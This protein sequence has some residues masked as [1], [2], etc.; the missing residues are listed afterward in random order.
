MAEFIKCAEACKSSC[1]FRK[2]CEWRGKY[3]AVCRDWPLKTYDIEKADAVFFTVNPE[4]LLPEIAKTFKIDPHI[5]AF[6]NEDDTW[7]LGEVPVPGQKNARVYFT[8]KTLSYEVMDLIC[9]INSEELRPYILLVTTRSAIRDT[10]DKLLRDMGSAFVPLNEVLN[11]NAQTDFEFI[12]ECKLPQ[13]IAPLEVEAEPEPDNIFRKC[14]DAWEVR[15]DGGEKFM[16]IGADT[17]AKYLHFMLGRPGESTPITEIIRKVSGE[18]ANI[19][20]ADRLEDGILTEGY[21]FNDLPDSMADNIADAKALR[22]YKEEIFRIK[23]DIEKAKSTGDNITAEQLEKDLQNLISMV[24]KIISPAGQKKSFTGSQKNQ[25]DAMRKT[26]LLTISKIKQLQPF[27]AKHLKSCIKFG[28][29]SGY[30][31]GLG[32]L[33]SS[34]DSISGSEYCFV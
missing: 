21:S 12:K 1:G 30:F 7:K 2:V 24:N 6:R 22:Q 5:R 19:V 11:F 33:T 4:N 14:G 31:P 18:S 9:R 23:H 34:I 16:L 26:I 20:S 8:L 25:L 29:N 32:L 15:F 28:K 13:L 27:L 3:E 17:G 10:S